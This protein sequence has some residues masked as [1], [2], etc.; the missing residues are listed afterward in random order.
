MKRSTWRSVIAAAAAAAGAGAAT[1]LGCATAMLLSGCPSVE[2]EA[3]RP[4][5][6]KGPKLLVY[7]PVLVAE[8]GAESPPAPEVRDKITGIVTE[9]F[10]R[11]GVMYE[12]AA[13]RAAGR[14][15]ACPDLRCYADIARK[16]D[17]EWMLFGKVF[18]F[19]MNRCYYRVT[20]T[21]IETGDSFT[22]VFPGEAR[23]ELVG[24][25]MR[26]HIDD[27]M[28][29][30]VCGSAEFYSRVLKTLTELYTDH[31]EALKR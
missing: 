29:L 1:A 16:D 27:P 19:V 15:T 21:S 9:I 25:E 10:G 3:D 14:S 5:S 2:V 22:K 31:K 30:A 20:L 26:Y 24:G 12:E 13:F 28:K 17:A 7:N 11:E 18:S 4:F 23:E 8:T 6:G